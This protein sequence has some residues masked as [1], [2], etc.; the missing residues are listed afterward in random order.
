MDVLAATSEG[1]A[2]ILTPPHLYCSPLPN[3][4]FIQCIWPLLIEPLRTMS[5]SNLQSIQW[6]DALFHLRCVNS[7]WKWLVETSSEWAAFRLARIDSRGLVKRGTS[8]QFACRHALEEYNNALI[9]LTTPRKL[10]V[11]MC[12]HPLLLPFPDICDRWLVVLKGV[13]E[14]ARNGTVKNP[15]LNDAYM[16]IPPEVGVH[17]SPKRAELQKRLGNL[18]LAA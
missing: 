4:V 14:S 7:Q 8:A 15:N 9:L 12:H 10:T 18:H 3:Y 6:F 5:A 2:A 16:Y 1:T 13:L 11:A 17:I